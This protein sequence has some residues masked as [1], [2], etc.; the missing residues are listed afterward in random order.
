MNAAMQ[1]K[2]Q[3]W[4]MLYQWVANDSMIPNFSQYVVNFEPQ[5]LGNDLL[6][7]NLG[8]IEIAQFSSSNQ[9]MS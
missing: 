4:G 1:R 2:L 5:L 9:F 8:K 6:F 3:S 7:R